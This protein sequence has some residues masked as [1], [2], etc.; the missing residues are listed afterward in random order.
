MWRSGVRRVGL[1]PLLG[2]DG[3]QHACPAVGDELDANKRRVPRPPCLRLARAQGPSRGWERGADFIA[4]R[5][6]LI[7]GVADEKA[8]A[9]T[10]AVIGL[11]R[12]A[13]VSVVLRARD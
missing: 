9:G 1:L 10:E 6:P 8:K 5:H 13:L 3:Q 12:M 2:L 11:R 4:Q 7:A